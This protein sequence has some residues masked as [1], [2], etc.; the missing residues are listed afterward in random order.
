MKNNI[1]LLVS[2]FFVLVGC[3]DF[4][5]KS[6]FRQAQS[7]EE[8]GFSS[9]RLARI[10]SFFA[11][12]IRCGRLPNAV[13]FVARHG[14]IAYFK[15]FGWRNVEN[16]IPAQKDDIYRWASQSK[17]VTSVGLMILYEQGKILLDDPLSKYLPEFKQMNVNAK[18]NPTD[19]VF[20]LVPVK[21]EVTIKHL[22]SHTAG[23][24]YY[25]KKV[26]S[27]IPSPGITMDDVTLEQ[28]IPDFAKIPL[29]H[30]PGAEFTYGYNTDILGRVIEVVSGMKLD[31][32]FRK[33]IFEPLGMNDTYFYLPK[34]KENR[35][36]TLYEQKTSGEK[37]Q[38]SGSDLWQNYPVKGARK[39]FS[40][41]AG[42]SGPIEDYAKLIQMLLNKGSLNG[43]QI[44]SPKTVEIMHTNQIGEVNCG[45]TGDKFGLGFRIYSQQSISSVIG[46]VGS[47]QW[48]GMFSTEY[49]VDPENDLVFLI[50]TNVQPFADKVEMLK[51]FRVLVYQA[52]LK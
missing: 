2:L 18:K 48:G 9:E 13:A 37:V 36:V 27:R 30:E 51:K 40:G 38:L 46:T 33:N 32:F 43:K 19:T 12:E 41:G 6:P 21:N 3:G 49:T 50:Y 39:F 24:P 47:Y 10:D 34:E 22:L 7:Q 16:K 17:A 25:S 29:N 15:N 35:L 20:T 42:L 52:M 23:I 8:L 26:Y 1:L 4:S 14:K 44:L 28:I 31:D 11:G 5:S 45:N